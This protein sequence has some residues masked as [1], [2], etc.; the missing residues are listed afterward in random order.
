MSHDRW[1]LDRVSTG[2]LA[3]EEDGSVELHAGS[4]SDY[5]ERKAREEAR[6]GTSV[7]SA[8]RAAPPAEERGAPPPSK[9]RRLSHAERRELDGMMDAIEQAEGRVAALQAK[10][11]DPETYQGEG[12]SVAALRTEL[13]AAEAEAQRLT[14]RWEELEE[15]A[16]ASAGR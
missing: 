5:R 15:I 1:L 14:A 6:A 7:A 4:Y 11:A 2:I 10:L 12:D 9:P 3:F 13:E 8:T 16:A